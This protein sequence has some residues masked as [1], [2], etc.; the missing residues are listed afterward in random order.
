MK[1]TIVNINKTTSWFFE[2]TNKIDKSLARLIKKKKKEKNQVN[3]IRNEKREV[4]RNNAEIQRLIR[5]HYEQLYG[6]K[7]DKL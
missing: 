3:N 4:T 5:D 2:K 1:E 6:N 7:I